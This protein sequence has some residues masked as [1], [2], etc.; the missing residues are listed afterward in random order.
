[1]TRLQHDLALKRMLTEAEQRA[2]TAEASIPALTSSLANRD[3]KIAELQKEIT[4]FKA[5]PAPAPIQQSP[6]PQPIISAMELE[7][8]RSQVALLGDVTKENEVLKASRTQS[9]SLSLASPYLCNFHPLVRDT[10]S[11]LRNAKIR[12]A[13]LEVALDSARK[14]DTDS[15]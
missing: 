14:G 6:P 10:D 8:L 15:K 4:S 3:L 5:T 2:L 12:Q 11:K 9:F 13:E 1:M 7:N